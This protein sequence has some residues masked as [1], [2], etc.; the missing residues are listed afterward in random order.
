MPPDLL[1]PLRALTLGG[2]ARLTTPALVRDW[3]RAAPSCCDQLGSPAAA[4]SLLAFV[5]SD[6]AP[7]NRGSVLG[8]A[9]LRCVPLADGSLGLLEPAGKAPPAGPPSVL[10]ASAAEETLLARSPLARAALVDGAAVRA[11]AGLEA[12]LAGLAATGWLSLRRLGAPDLAETF[13]PPLL[14][15]PAVPGERHAAWEPPGRDDTWLASV[16]ELLAGYAGL[17]P[18]EAAALPLV[19][20]ACGRL[21]TLAPVPTTSLLRQPPQGGGASW[22]RPLTCL[23]QRLGCFLL[24][25]DSPAA[26]HPVRCHL[27]FRSPF[28]NNTV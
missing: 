23:L 1:A 13:L 19:P 21:H 9:G 18:F 14:P 27:P 4:A 20:T 10:L 8:L 6:V 11:V 2:R 22:A 12:T 25:P 7:R 17:R 28:S 5:A 26:A 3:V 16:W 24:P 15:R